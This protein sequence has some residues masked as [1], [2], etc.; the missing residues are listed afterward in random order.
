MPRLIQTKTILSSLKKPDS[1]FGFSY[2][3]NL[4]RGCQHQCI[5]CDSRSTC[6]QLGDLADI[7]IKENALLLLEKELKSKRKRTTIG[8]GS[9]NDPDMP[10]EK[11]KNSIF[12]F[13]V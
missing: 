11:K 9:M 6:Y 1:W 13:R 5:Y 10:V 12:T 2:S 7:R 8:F 4:Y 3:L